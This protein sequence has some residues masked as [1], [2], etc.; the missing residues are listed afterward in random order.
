MQ[1]VLVVSLAI[2]KVF[3]SYYKHK[4]CAPVYF[5]RIRQTIT[6]DSYSLYDRILFFMPSFICT[7]YICTVNVS[8]FG[9]SDSEFSNVAIDN[10]LPLVVMP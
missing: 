9:V 3:V 2:V 10:V 5:I 8:A 7:L 1:L 4:A 6:Q